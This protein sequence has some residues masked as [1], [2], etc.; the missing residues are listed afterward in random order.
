MSLFDD[1]MQL[2]IV[3]GLVVV[4]IMWGPKKIPE[5][6]RALGQAK[7]EFAAGAAQ[8]PVGLGG[9]ASTFASVTSPAVATDPVS[10]TGTDTALIETA[11]RLGISAQGKTA[12]QISNAIVDRAN[13]GR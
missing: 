6:A 13:S 4:F 8:K 3:G 12:E 2:L 5:L 7:N 11:A 10:A 1:P 9:L